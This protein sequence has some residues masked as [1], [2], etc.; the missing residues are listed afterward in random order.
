MMPII[1]LAPNR[2]AFSP[3]FLKHLRRLKQRGYKI[4][5]ITNQ[6]GI[7]RGFFT[8]EQYRAVEAEVAAANG[9]RLDRCDLFL[10]GRAGPTLKTPQTRAGNGPAGRARA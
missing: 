1:V 7:G 2:C 5:V 9:Q 4:I 10:S 8:V 6:S 3:V